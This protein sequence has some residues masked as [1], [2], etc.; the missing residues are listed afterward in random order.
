LLARIIITETVSIDQ[1][2]ILEDLG[3]KAGLRV[4]LKFRAL[5]RALFNRRM[6][7]PAS[8]PRCPMLGQD[9]RIG[10][11]SPYIVVYRHTEVDDTV[12]VSFTAAGTS[13]RR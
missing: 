4:A 13:P 1:A 10:I 11:V 2:T 7:H 5:F 6:D 9:V 8:G 3:K 12:S